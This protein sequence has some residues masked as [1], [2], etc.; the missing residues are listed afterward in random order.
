MIA[1][2]A[3]LLFA[4]PIR[5]EKGVKVTDA[6]Q[7]AL[8]ATLAKAGIDPAVAVI[9]ADEVDAFDVNVTMSYANVYGTPKPI[10][11]GFCRG[12]AWQFGLD[13]SQW[14]ALPV[15]DGA[16]TYIEK[17]CD[18]SSTTPRT[19]VI[20]DVPDALLA[21]I[22]EAIRKVW[23]AKGP[24]GKPFVQYPIPDGLGSGDIFSIQ[25]GRHSYFAKVYPP[26]GDPV[27]VS[28]AAHHGPMLIYSV[29]PVHGLVKD[30]K[31]IF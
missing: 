26:T 10:G 31:E 28:V 3:A 23:L 15:E 17:P 24:D 4:V 7:E 6:Q 20:G 8:R 29:L 11:S 22:V 2:V 27:Y 21:G 13:G 25:R 18:T 19:F 9:R 12:S 16:L 14:V 1:L 5:V 30:P